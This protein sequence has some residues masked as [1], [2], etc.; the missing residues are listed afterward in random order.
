MALTAKAFAPAAI[1]N[2][3]AIYYGGGSSPDSLRLA[4]ATG[5]G[6]ALSSGVVTSAWVDRDEAGPGISITVNGDPAYEA[7][8]TK[9]AVKLLLQALGEGERRI[10]LV[11]TVDVPIGYGFRASAASALSGVVAVASA[12]STK[13]DREGVAYFAHAADILCR[14]G[15]GTVSVIYKHGGAGVIVSPGAPGLAKVLPVKVPKGV[16]V[17]TASLAP[18]GKASLL[19]SPEMAKRVS[20]LG[21]ESVRIASDGTLESLLRAGEA[22]SEGL[23]IGSPQVRRLAGAAKSAGALGASQ[24]MVGQ[25]VHAVVWES[26]AE[27]VASAMREV[28][29]SA[30]VRVHR[31]APGPAR[32]LG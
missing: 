18:Y 32:T 7:T 23:H 30:A 4:G 21:A 6:F 12:L 8:T 5:G 1:S 10:E 14:T 16:R 9:T 11:Q 29:P 22:F 26:D 15:L 20:I 19:S 28:E 31:L 27:R 2:F 25:A 13:L 24:N 3:F 17:V